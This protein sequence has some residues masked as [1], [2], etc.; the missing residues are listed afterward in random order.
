M[1]YCLLDNLTGRTPSIFTQTFHH[2]IDQIW[3]SKYFWE[4]SKQAWFSW[5]YKY[6]VGRL[7]TSP[8]EP[9]LVWR[10]RG[11]FAFK[12]E[13]KDKGVIG[14]SNRLD[15]GLIE[16]YVSSTSTSWHTTQYYTTIL[17]DY[18]DLRRL[19]WSHLDLNQFA[20]VNWD[21]ASLSLLLP[22]RVRADRRR[23]C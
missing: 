23:W 3:Y 14:N 20:I 6:K 7:V 12:R 11:N 21:Q 9:S 19:V 5:L 13:G 18:A 16:W 2:T 10:R 4:G 17:S 8:H 15:F 1:V 22:V